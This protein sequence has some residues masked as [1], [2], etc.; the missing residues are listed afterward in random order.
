M[1]THS[2]VPHKHPHPS[3]S[4]IHTSS[5]P[6]HTSH[7]PSDLPPQLSHTDTHTSTPHTAHTR[8]YHTHTGNPSCLQHL[9][10]S[11]GSHRGISIPSF[12]WREGSGETKLL[13][14]PE[15]WP[16]LAGC[17]CLL[18]SPS[19]CLPGQDPP[20]TK[21]GR[22]K[23]PRVSLLAGVSG[24]ALWRGLDSHLSRLDT[25]QRSHDSH[26]QIPMASEG[27]DC[28]ASACPGS[29]NV[30]LRTL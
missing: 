22:N 8:L 26:H 15:R 9:L 14:T 7:T 12:L 24:K 25:V 4:Y 2:H 10:P 17:P 23:A 29:Q 16:Y 13:A 5:Y 20:G 1:C 3:L 27:S 28:K 11:R 6:T 30:L 18:E 19:L 21:L